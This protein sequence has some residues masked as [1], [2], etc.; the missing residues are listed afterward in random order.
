M[1][2]IGPYSWTPTFT[3]LAL[4]ST[5]KRRASLIALAAKVSNAC[6]HHLAA[7]PE[8][9][10]L[11]P[12]VLSPSDKATL[13]DGYD[14][15][16]VEVKRLLERMRQSLSAEHLDLCPY[17]SLDT[18]AQ[19]DH[20]LPSSKYPEFALYGPNLL[21]ICPVCNQSK[22]TS[23][24]DASQRRLFLMVSDDEAIRERV[25]KAMVA[26]VPQP[27][28]TFTIDQSAAVSASDLALI[29]RH[30][31]RLG[32][33]TR[34]RRRAHSLLAALK[35]RLSEVLKGRDLS[36]RRELTRRIISDGR[37]IALMEEPTN[38]WRVALYR[39]LDAEGA[40]FI[41]WLAG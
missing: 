27:H 8:V 15:R 17:C 18:T 16:S 31:H 30:F 24:V 20:Y 13:I 1:R 5:E 11:A 33:A 22:G 6:G 10:T 41:N 25:L 4:A 12:K 26:M 39:A 7:K 34:Y 23:V 40:T 3:D 29:Q 14:G 9:H 37:D 32:L 28:I 35:R 21:P 19:I 36:K 2:Y 38:G